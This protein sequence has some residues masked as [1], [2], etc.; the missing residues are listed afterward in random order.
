MKKRLIIVVFLLFAISLIIAGCGSINDHDV[1]YST[2]DTTD[3]INENSPHEHNS[4][5][6]DATTEERNDS[7]VDLMSFSSIDAFLTYTLNA[8]KGGDV[9]DLS[10][11]DYF[12]LPTGLPEGYNL[13]RIAAGAVDIGFYYLQDEYLS[14]N[15]TARL[16]E[17]QRKNFLFISNRG[18]YQFKSVMEQF[19]VVEDDLIDGKYLY[20]EYLNLIIWEQDDVTLMLYLP[21]EYVISD[22]HELCESAQYIRNKDTHSFDLVKY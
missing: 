20:V 5:L 7:P 3:N 13:N 4:D 11:L 16:A 6:P 8:E 14:T 18:S 9:A 21:K 22:I 2:S 17:A 10:S 12:F 15:E 1:E 19:S